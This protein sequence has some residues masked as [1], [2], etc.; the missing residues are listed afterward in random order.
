MEWKKFECNKCS[1]EFQIE[2]QLKKHM[3]IKKEERRKKKKKKGKI[4][5]GK[6]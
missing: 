4:K 2:W 6:K 1:K 3:G 5:E